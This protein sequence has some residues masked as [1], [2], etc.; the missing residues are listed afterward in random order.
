MIE[1]GEVVICDLCQREQ[2]RDDVAGFVLS[3][4]SRTL[5]VEATEEAKIHI[6]GLCLS[7]LAITQT[8]RQRQRRAS[9]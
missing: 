9:C 1:P 3:P 6:C 2:E 4:H 7:L 5:H 8:P